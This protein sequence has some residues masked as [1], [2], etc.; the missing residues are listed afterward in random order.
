MP[1]VLNKDPT[2]SNG[3]N[4]TFP[5]ALGIPESG[6]ECTAAGTCTRNTWLVG[7]VNAAPYIA[8]SFL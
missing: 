4:L 6:D 3:A 8:I 5:V 2:G 7:L 1:Q